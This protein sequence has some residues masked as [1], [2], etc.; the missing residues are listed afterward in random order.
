MS[1]TA[2]DPSGSS[3][4]QTTPRL[5]IL[6]QQIKAKPEN[7]QAF[8]NRG[9]TLAL[10]GRKEEARADIKR[11]VTLSDKAPM[12]NRAGWAYFNMGDYTDSVREF[13]TAAKLSDFKAHYDYYSR[14]YERMKK[15]FDAM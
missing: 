10:L 7:A 3:L 5:E 15:P 14:V 8:C 2:A 4:V 1:A 11:S 9:Y 12:H 13:E 6:N